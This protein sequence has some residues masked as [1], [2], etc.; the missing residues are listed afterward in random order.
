MCRP[1]VDGW[2]EGR[3]EGQGREIRSPDCRSTETFR[4][5]LRRSVSL[6]GR[7]FFYFVVLE[8]LVRVKYI[9]MG[10]AYILFAIKTARKRRRHHDRLLLLL[11]LL[12]LRLLRFRRRRCFLLRPRESGERLYRLLISLRSF[13]GLHLYFEKHKSAA[14]LDQEADQPRIRESDRTAN[15]VY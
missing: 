12:L 6:A 15:S 9:K 11:L 5:R 13:L 10:A 2:G 4:R 3:G 14:L 1:A 7:F 8:A